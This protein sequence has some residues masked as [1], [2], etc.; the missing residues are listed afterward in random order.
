M[1]QA[2]V[3]RALLPAAVSIEQ[4]S[5]EERPLHT[6]PAAKLQTP[7]HFLHIAA[8]PF[9]LAPSYILIQKA[10]LGVPLFF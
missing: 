7:A 10:K 6:Y 2:C 4:I 3:E 5:G 8:S 9:F 1:E